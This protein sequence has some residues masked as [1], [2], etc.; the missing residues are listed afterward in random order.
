[1]S[2]HTRYTSS[3]TPVPDSEI[4]RKR[5]CVSAQAQRSIGPCKE[6]AAVKSSNC[7]CLQNP[8][9]GGNADEEV[10]QGSLRDH[11]LPQAETVTPHWLKAVAPEAAVNSNVLR[12]FDSLRDG[13]QCFAQVMQSVTGK[14]SCL[15]RHSL[16]ISA[17][18]SNTVALQDSNYQRSDAACQHNLKQSPVLYPPAFHAS[19]SQLASA[20]QVACC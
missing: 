3:Q 20:W 5:M 8:D 2:W 12:I 13:D 9:C 10:E 7:T 19:T 1:M 18:L 11:F 4:S 15:R 17:P 6:E 14:P 16:S